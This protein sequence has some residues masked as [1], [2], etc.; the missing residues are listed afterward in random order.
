MLPHWHF[1]AQ[2]REVR[3]GE[4]T[5]ER[6]RTGEQQA[7]DAGRPIVIPF[8]PAA[9]A[10]LADCSAEGG[11]AVGSARTGTSRGQ[12]GAGGEALP[13]PSGA[14]SPRSGGTVWNR[15]TT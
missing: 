14:L 7:P 3:G 15:G 9:A 1:P 4:A 10:G 11:A 13:P 8:L 5:P 12:A 6:K 2:G